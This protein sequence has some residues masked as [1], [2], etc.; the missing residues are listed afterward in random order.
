MR[1]RDWK[2]DSKKNKCPTYQSTCLFERKI[3]PLDIRRL[4]DGLLLVKEKM[5]KIIKIIRKEE[6]QSLENKSGLSVIVQDEKGVRYS[7]ILRRSWCASMYMFIGKDWCKFVKNNCVKE[8]D[9]LKVMSSHYV[10]RDVFGKLYLGISVVSSLPRKSTEKLV[11]KEP[12]KWWW[13]N[14]KT[15]RFVLFL[16][17][18]TIKYLYSAQI[19]LIFMYVYSSFIFTSTL[20]FTH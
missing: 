20:Y 15:S 12:I 7:V 3:F 2:L 16:M 1:V 9:I 11:N 18:N 17:F 6:R 4:H 10:R 13:P 19:Y 8:L 5:T 14:M